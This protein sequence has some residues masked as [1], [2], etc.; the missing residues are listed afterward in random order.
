[1]DLK[2]LKWKLRDTKSRHQRGERDKRGVDYLIAKSIGS[3]TFTNFGNTQS[4]AKL[5]KK[6]IF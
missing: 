1:L 6:K 2:E 4:F 3:D 5:Y